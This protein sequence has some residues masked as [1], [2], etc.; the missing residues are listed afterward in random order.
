MLFLWRR[1]GES[2]MIGDDIEVT[3]MPR[4]HDNGQ[5]CICVKAPKEIPVHRREVYDRIAR[6]RAE[7]GGN[8]S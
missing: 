3:L 4:R 5:Y 1:K 6:E 2:I 7:V 8:W